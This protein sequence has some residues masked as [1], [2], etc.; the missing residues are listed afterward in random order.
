MKIQVAKDL[1]LNCVKVQPQKQEI[2]DVKQPTNHIVIIDCSGSMSSALPQIRT[3]L[4]NKLPNLVKEG[5]TVSLIWFSGKGQFGLLAEK[6]KVQDLTDLQR[7]NTAIDRWLH[8]VGLTGFVQPLKEALKIATI[9]SGAYSLFFLTDGYD[10]QWNK[11]EILDATRDLKAVLS[12]AVFVEYGWYCNRPLMTEMAEELGGNLVFCENFDAYEPI[13]SSTLAKSFKSSK[14]IVL[15]IGKPLHDLVFS[16]ADNAPCTYK[17]D[18]GKVQIPADVDVV[19]WYTNDVTGT[20]DIKELKSQDDLKPIY[21]S[22]AALSQRMKSSMVKQILAGLG[23]KKLWNKF[24]NAFGKQN[25]TDFQKMTIEA[26]EG[27]MFEEGRDY[28]LK[29]DD[30]AFTILD[31]LFMLSDDKENEFVPSKM[32]YK[33]ISRATEDAMDDLTEAERD[34]IADLTSKAKTAK[35]LQ[36]VQK[37]IEEIQKSKPKKLTFKRKEGDGGYPIDGLVWNEDRPNASIRV[38][39]DGTVEI[40]DDCEFVKS[41]V[42]PKIFPTSQYRNYTIICD[43]IANIPELPVRLSKA[44]FASLKGIGIVSGNYKADEVYMINLRDLPTINQNM[45][46]DISAKELFTLQYELTKLKSVQMVYKA[47][48]KQWVGK[49]ESEGFKEKYGEVAT[50]W[51]TEQGFSDYGGFNPKRKQAE[52]T[53]FY[54]GVELSVSL[55]GFDSLPKFADFSKKMEAKEKKPLTPK[56]LLLEGSYKDCKS[57]D[58]TKSIT[59]EKKTW[60]ESKEKESIASTRKMI[61]KMAEIKFGVIVGQAWFNEFASLDENTLKMKFD[62]NEVECKAILKDIE[63]KI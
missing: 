5:D 8:P 46:K 53:D 49:R 61:K 11:N 59:E 20:I 55:K 51:L 9:G 7:L 50:T 60:I 23:D 45:I 35:D 16:V 1:A 21:Q 42:L 18:N 33:K 3:Q 2:K 43:G 37:R 4:K 25:L 15:E 30:N 22:V 34:E 52:S 40:P 26:A 38:K 19:Y 32:N 17:I 57:Q 41:K 6:V 47:F 29:S 58:L 36:T 12:G 13:I 14:K 63:I 44:T 39:F 10:N 27:K 28:N 48:K 31:L 54:V 24:S 56:E 62:G